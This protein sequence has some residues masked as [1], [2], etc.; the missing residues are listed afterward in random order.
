MSTYDFRDPAT[1]EKIRDALKLL[2]DKVQFVLTDLENALNTEFPGKLGSLI[3]IANEYRHDPKSNFDLLV[4]YESH[5]QN[6]FFTY[7]NKNLM[8]HISKMHS[9]EAFSMKDELL[10]FDSL[11]YTQGRLY[12]EIEFIGDQLE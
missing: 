11:R 5:S 12:K 8:N 4:G 6:R 10:I 2:H 1:L 3:L 9:A 7:L